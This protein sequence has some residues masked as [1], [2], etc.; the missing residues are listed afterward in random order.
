[1][2]ATRPTTT[3]QSQSA[4]DKPPSEGE[5]P[6]GGWTRT[7]SSLSNPHFRLLWIS[8]LFSF[9][10][11]Q[12]SFTA[13]GFLT[14]DLTG[15]A[16]SLGFVSLGWG[17]PLLT[18]SLFGGVAADRM[19]KR[20]L[21]IVSQAVM[22]VTSVLTAVLIQT[23]VIEVWQIF[24][25]A[26]A[27]GTVFAFNVPARQAWIPELVREEQL[28][29]A[30]A[31]NSSAFT[32]TGIVGPALAGMLIAVPLIGLAGAY[33]LMAGCFTIVVLL[34]LRIPGGGPVAVTDRSSPLREL[35]DGLSY[36][37]HH[38]VLPVLLLMGFVPIVLAMT[39]RTFFPVFQEDV[40][41]VGSVGLGLMGA[42]MA[43]GAVVGSLGVASLPNTSRR[44]L[45]Q[46][47]G[48]IGFGIS[49]VLFAAAPTLVPGLIALL[50]V[51]LTS[52]GYWALN[53]TM[54]LGNTDGEYY[55]RV[56][57]VY[58]LSW[59]FMPFAAMPQ[60]ALADAYGVQWM[61]A[62]VGILLVVLIVAMVALP[63]YRRLRDRETHLAEAAAGS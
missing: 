20:W 37:R 46:L 45:I 8:M 44:S 9:T 29:N 49:L 33:Y 56:M 13:Q 54:V 28:M 40:Y 6:D 43:V 55:G 14:F 47:A 39:Y 22:A 51:G 60:S 63:G 18:L 31:L 53:T 26:V 32:A 12:M 1:M 10:A 52:N 34:L 3:S 58:M 36:I 17:I 25:L 24:V 41:G 62:G 21:M 48:G 30:I 61:I 57:S 38:S 23:G 11:I 16:T 19:H 59:S 2:N 35:V 50:F 42:F 5:P 7:F 27:T 15:T 4:A